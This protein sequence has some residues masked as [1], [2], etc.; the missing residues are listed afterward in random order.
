MEALEAPASPWWRL[1]P[2]LPL[3]L[4]FFLLLLFFFLLLLFFSLATK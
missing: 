1:R 3:L 2:P 4:F